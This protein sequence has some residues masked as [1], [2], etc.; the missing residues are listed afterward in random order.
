M[1][2][3]TCLS[4]S[5]APT[6]SSDGRCAPAPVRRWEGLGV[7]VD[8]VDFAGAVGLIQTMLERRIG[9]WVATPNPD[10]VCSAWRDPKLRAVLCDASLSV[11]D[12]I[13]IV[14]A[15]RVLGG[16]ALSR[17]AGSDL[18][19]EAL[20]FCA[21]QGLAVYILGGR[22][23]VAAGAGRR[24]GELWPGLRVVGTG[25][26]YFD[27][28]AEPEV[29]ARVLKAEPRLIVVGMGHPRQEMWLAENLRAVPGAVG[30]ACGGTI[31]ILAGVARRAP[32]WVRR[33]NLEWLYRLISA[34][35][36][37]A[38]RA[39]NLPAFVARVLGLR[40]GW[41][42]RPPAPDSDPE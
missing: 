8:D 11:A 36:A 7:P 26:G 18:V 27:R 35:R 31:D 14:W 22:P 2:K 19:S 28:A 17:V 37:R 42:P 24:A 1:P 32:R 4:W 21:R 13:G 38:R 25:H 15:S 3:R 41:I 10:I 5:A 29:L 33:A 6:R 12:G 23:G 39:L 40:V 9:G 20:S 16:P 30:I 34:P